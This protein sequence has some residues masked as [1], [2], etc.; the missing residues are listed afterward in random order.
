MNILIPGI[1]QLFKGELFAESII[2]IKG[3]AGTLKSA[4]SF[5]LMANYLMNYNNKFGV[6]LTLEQSWESHLRNMN[7]I[8]IQLPENLLISD[9]NHMRREINFKEQKFDVIEG[10]KSILRRFKEEMGDNF[11]FFVLD[12]LNAF[13]ALSNFKNSR[14]A[15]FNFF[16][17]LRRLGLI[18]LII[19]ENLDGLEGCSHESYLSDGIILLGV[20]ELGSNVSRYIQFIKIRGFYHNLKK[21]QLDIRDGNLIVLKPIFEP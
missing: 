5:S 7:S 4:L 14:L 9:Y 1:E 21:F 15:L 13:S 12:S 6:Y 17:F 19:K 2:L 18:S 20:L 3:K 8:G 16:D 10:I 11:C